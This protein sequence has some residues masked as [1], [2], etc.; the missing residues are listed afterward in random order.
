VRSK[1]EAIAI[2]GD[3][4]RAPISDVVRAI[5]AKEPFRTTPIVVLT[6]LT[7]DAAREIEETCSF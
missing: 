5:R 7:T 4:D 1:F 3:A 6:M 2:G